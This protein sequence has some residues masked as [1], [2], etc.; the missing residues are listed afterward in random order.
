MSNP[1]KGEVNFECGGK[2]YTFKLGTNAQV[3]LEQKVKMP[4]SK[5]LKQDRIED[6]G[7]VDLRSIFWAGLFRQ[8]QLTEE[9][10][11]DIIDNIGP[12]KVA[13]IFLEAFESAKVKTE[14]G[15]AGAGG[16]GTTTSPPLKS[17]RARTGMNS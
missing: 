9:E 17:A 13:D 14:N 10:V 7:I 5:F 2:T 6:L 3:M 4:M 1:V 15:V 8:H 12:E 16:P 11:G